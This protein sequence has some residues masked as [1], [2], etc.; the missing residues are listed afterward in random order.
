LPKNKRALDKA[1][2]RREQAI[3]DVKLPDFLPLLLANLDE[4]AKLPEVSHW[5]L[6]IDVDRDAEDAYLIDSVRKK[7]SSYDTARRL[8][9][10]IAELSLAELILEFQRYV[11]GANPMVNPVL[12]EELFVKHVASDK[13][14]E[15]DFRDL[16]QNDF[17]SQ[18]MWSTR[19]LHFTEV[20]TE[21]VPQERTMEEG[22]LFVNMAIN[23]PF[24]DVVWKSHGEM[25][26]AQMTVSSTHPKPVS[27]F[28]KAREKL[29]MP[30]ESKLHVWYVM[31]PGKG[32]DN[33]AASFFW[34]NVES[35]PTLIA[36]AE[37]M[38][39]FGI[40]ELPGDFGSRGERAKAG[41]QGEDQKVIP[42][43]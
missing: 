28:L 22:V 4:N 24:V 29:G 26:S 15:W 40:L 35:E 38:L 39:S 27:T 7:I 1:V 21:E 5:F 20:R 17:R 2:E 3:N 12:L 18:E 41:G 23:F 14:V 34:K 36:E 43:F 6:R 13:G 10:K 33:I 11:K 25:H 31:L 30:P 16:S 8:R 32:R 42:K 19:K 37:K 9:A